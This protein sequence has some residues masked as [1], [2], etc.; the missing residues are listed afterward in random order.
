MD[1]MNGLRRV[2]SVMGLAHWGA[3][4]AGLLAATWAFRAVPHWWLAAPAAAGACLAGTFLTG[5]LWVV[6]RML[7]ELC[8][9]IK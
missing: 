9:G 8:E 3:L 7:I 2:E 6:V 5:S 1:Q 4:V